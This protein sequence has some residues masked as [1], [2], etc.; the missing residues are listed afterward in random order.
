MQPHRSAHSVQLD[1]AAPVARQPQ[2]IQPR[3]QPTGGAA[4]KARSLTVVRIASVVLAAALLL[5]AALLQADGSA[6]NV[7]ADAMARMMEAMGFLGDDTPSGTMPMNPG[8][9]NPGNFSMPG[10]MPG[11]NQFGMNPFAQQPWSSALTNPTQTF[12]MDQMMQQLP[13]MQQM[14]QVPGMPGWQRT[15]LDGIWEGR[16]GSLLIVQAH[17]FRLYA[18]QGGYVDG[19]IQ[20]RGDRLAL[21]DPQQDTARPF[22]YAEHQGRLVLRDPEGQVYLYRRLW[23]DDDGGAGAS[24]SR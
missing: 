21:Y 10:M 4:R 20:Q 23:L 3:C 13:G 18:S 8:P 11:M 6:R 17:R 16:G 14:P 2:V 22:E 15:A 7:M 5:P 9:M 12:G 19:L 24:T 1:L